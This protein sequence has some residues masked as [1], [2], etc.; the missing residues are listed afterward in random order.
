ML[1]GPG[2]VGRLWATI[3][4]LT[5]SFDVFGRNK[6]AIIRK[7]NATALV[8]RPALYHGAPLICGKTHGM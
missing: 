7:T 6:A 3:L 8:K 1:V 2:K 4:C 5:S